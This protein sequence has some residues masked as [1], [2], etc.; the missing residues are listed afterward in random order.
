[1][2]LPKMHDRYWFCADVLSFILAFAQPQTWP[3]AVVTIAVSTFSY[4]PYLL[5]KTFISMK[6]LSLALGIFSIYL[7]GTSIN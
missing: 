4:T 2:L 3:V 6:V 5:G 1:L 7:W